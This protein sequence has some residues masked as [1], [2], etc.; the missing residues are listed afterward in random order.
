VKAARFLH[1]WLPPAAL[2]ALLY[3]ASSTDDLPSVDLFSDKLMHLA[4]YTLL[5]LLFLR[6][7]HGGVPAGLR[8]LPTLA[9]VFATAAYGGLD[10]IHQGFVEGRFRDP[11]DFAADLGGAL[12]ATVLLALWVRFVRG[13]P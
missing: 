10:E 13:K 12:L 5:G 7:F 4:A 6:A 9:A 11:A 1:L 8:W 3:L 2:M